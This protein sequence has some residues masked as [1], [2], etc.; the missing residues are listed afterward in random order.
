MLKNI[1]IYFV[2]K[3]LGISLEIFAIKYVISMKVGNSEEKEENLK[4]ANLLYKNSVLFKG[5]N[6]SKSLFDHKCVTSQHFLFSTQCFC[7]SFETT[8]YL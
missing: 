8:M 6:E 5:I 1:I 2:R 3:D 7:S 4:K